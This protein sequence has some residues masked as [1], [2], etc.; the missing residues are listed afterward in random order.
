LERAGASADEAARV[1]ALLA[2]CDGVRFVPGDAA[3]DAAN[4]LRASA[5]DLVRGLLRGAARS[6]RGGAA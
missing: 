2:A 4:D 3:A 1:A 5:N 6:R